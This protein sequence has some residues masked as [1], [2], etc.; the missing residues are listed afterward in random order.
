MAGLALGVPVLTT[1][2]DLTEPLWAGCGAV[3]LVGVK[4]LAASGVAAAE[5]LLCDD[6][7]RRRVGERGQT[8]YRERFAIEHTIA[9][10][11]EQSP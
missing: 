8:L 4:N 9:A 2:G 3:S 11:R 1:S 7:G 5:A 6:P 10:L